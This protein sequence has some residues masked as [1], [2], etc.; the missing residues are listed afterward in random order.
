MGGILTSVS[1]RHK[2]SG[3]QMLQF[4]CAPH[5]AVHLEVGIAGSDH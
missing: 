1:L 2:C 4:V 5:V 3:M